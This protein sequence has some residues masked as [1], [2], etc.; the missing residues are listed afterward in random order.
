M[1]AAFD[2]DPAVVHLNHGSF[3]AV[4]RVVAQAQRRVRAHAEA[5]PMRFHR[6]ELPGL[7]EHARTIAAG[8]LGVGAGDVALVRNVTQAAASVLASLADSGR[9]TSDDA[10]I[11]SDHTYESVRELALRACR[12]TGASYE[13]VDFAVDADADAVVAAYRRAFERVWSRGLR[14]SV[15]LV[16]HIVSPT[17]AIMPVSRICAA[18]RQAGALSFVDAAHVPGQIAARPAESGADFWAGSWH[19]WGFAPRGTSALWAAPH[20]RERLLP[21]ASGAPGGT[22]YPLPFDRTGTDDYTGWCCLQDA[23]EF[24]RDAGGPDIAR[25]SSA[26]LDTGAAVVRETLGVFEAPTPLR[27]APC[28]RL[29][30]LPAGAATT[31]ADASRLYDRLSARGIE[32]QVVAHAERGYLRLSASLYN[33]PDDYERLAKVL[34]ETLAANA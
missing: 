15:V 3:G 33:T 29:V 34:P 18:A 20:V 28:M 12:R 31:A 32:V 22:P 5:N 11:L 17:G 19:K 30:A 13:L 1:H 10:V 16:D 7:K 9:L 27:A 21:L 8:F 6:V 23:I 14:P 4:P 25:R 2:L 24:W 26:L